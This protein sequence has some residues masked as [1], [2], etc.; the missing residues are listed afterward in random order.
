MR[1]VQDPAANYEVT[2]KPS[3]VLSGDGDGMVGNFEDEVFGKVDPETFKEMDRK[4][5]NQKTEVKPDPHDGPALEGCAP[6][7][8][9]VAGHDDHHTPMLFTSS[10]LQL[11]KECG[12]KK[13][14]RPQKALD[15]QAEEGSSIDSVFLD[16]RAVGE[17]GRIPSAEKVGA[18]I[19]LDENPASSHLQIT[20]GGFIKEKAT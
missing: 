11:S 7:F 10:F 6:A 18:K 20:R 16:D 12:T 9:P 1:Q 8:L 4:L 19:G 17:V 13:E 3:V 5:L 15:V 14:D 2:L